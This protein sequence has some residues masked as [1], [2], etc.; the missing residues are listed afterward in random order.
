MTDEDVLL[1]TGRQIEA[2]LAGRHKAVVDV[3]RQ[4]YLAHARGEDVLPPSGILRFPD[5]PENRIIALPAHIGGPKPVTGIKWISSFPANTQAGMERA[6]AVILVNSPRTGRVEAMIEGSVI[7]ARRTAASAVLTA[8]EVYRGPEPC[9]LGLIGGGRINFEI[10]QFALAAGPAIGSIVVHDT[11]RSRTES[12]LRRCAEV[13]PDVPVSA[14]GTVEDVLARASLVA[15]ATTAVSPHVTDLSMCPPQ[16]TI[17]HVSLRDIAPEAI[18]AADNVV[19]DVAH[20]LTAQTSVHLAEQLTGN[21]DFIRAT[22]GDVL[23]G[24]AP[25]RAETDRPLVFSPFGMG[26]LDIALAGAVLEAVRDEALPVAGFWPE[27]WHSGTGA[28]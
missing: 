22:I 12:F 5:Q 9:V 11:S 4:A 26:T 7:S 2:A 23:L 18:L 20:V 15:F 14:A 6:S 17:L 10:L 24:R 16:T 28:R 25:R 8:S 27:P 19:D 21:H 13:A 3:I 1:V